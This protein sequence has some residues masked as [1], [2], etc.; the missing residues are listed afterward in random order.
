VSAVWIPDGFAGRGL[1]IPVGFPGTLANG[2]GLM[3]FIREFALSG[4][5]GLCPP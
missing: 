3:L 2:H 4:V 1:G 5:E